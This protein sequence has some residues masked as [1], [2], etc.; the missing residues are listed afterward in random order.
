MTT[1]TSLVD[2][3]LRS[4]R[5]NMDRITKFFTAQSEEQLQQEIAPGKNRL[6]YL[7]GHLAAINDA[8]LPLLDIGP[9]LHPELDPLF[10]SNPDRLSPK[11]HSGAELKRIWDEIDQSLW[12]AFPQWSPSEWLQKHTAVSEEDFAREPHR[13]R[14]TILLG[15]TTHLS[16]HLGQALLIRP[17]KTEA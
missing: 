6:I 9:R 17:R 5:S 10:V 1:E 12:T 14:Y 13:N 15:R 4:W 7:W 3:A 8:L 16:Y 11:T 2:S